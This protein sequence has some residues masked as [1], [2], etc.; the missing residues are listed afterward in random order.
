M[1][2]VRKRYLM[3]NR[4]IEVHHKREGGYA[5]QVGSSQCW[6]DEIILQCWCLMLENAENTQHLWRGE[7]VMINVL[8]RDNQV[9]GSN[10][11]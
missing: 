9:T 3:S 5:I 10:S 8:L 1:L 2:A 11:L 6:N 4:I 7:S